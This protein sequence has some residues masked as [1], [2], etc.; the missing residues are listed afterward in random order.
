MD[1]SVGDVAPSRRPGEG[2]EL[3][4]MASAV[5]PHLVPDLE[6]L[7]PLGLR[8]DDAS[9]DASQLDAAL[10]QLLT[11]FRQ[12][13]AV[14]S[15]VGCERT[16]SVAP[17]ATFAPELRP[18]ELRGAVSAARPSQELHLIP[19][20][21]DERD[22]SNGVYRLW[23]ISQMFPNKQ[24]FYILYTIYFVKAIVLLTIRHFYDSI[25]LNYEKT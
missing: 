23:C 4:I 7:E 20:Q 17:V 9:T 5:A 8:D 1:K 2:M 14:V 15:G 25:N 11:K 6:L 13:L 22:T 10:T 12:R 16:R 19:P 18:G 24:E 21:R 3:D